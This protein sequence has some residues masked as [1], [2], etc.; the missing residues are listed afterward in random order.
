MNEELRE[1]V[2][3]LNEELREE[4]QELREEVQKLIKLVEGCEII[5]RAT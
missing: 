3:E 2:H 1:E 4:I 5:K